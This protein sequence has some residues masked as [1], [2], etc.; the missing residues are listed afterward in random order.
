MTGVIVT[1]VGM[2]TAAMS[3]VVLAWFR[4]YLPVGHP[5]RQLWHIW[6]LWPTTSIWVDVFKMILV[7]WAAGLVVVGAMRHRRVEPELI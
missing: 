2:A 1:A 3:F 5:L 6:N 7:G 4:I